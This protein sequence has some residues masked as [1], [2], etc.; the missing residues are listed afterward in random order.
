ME[1]V[2]IMLASIG[3]E[4]EGNRLGLG[5]NLFSEEKTNFE[6]YGTEY[7]NGELKK[8]SNFYNYY[9]LGNETEL[10]Q[11]NKRNN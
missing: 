10:V 5:V 8:N 6:K 11:E 2:A 4:I 9:I 1:N 3:V 7:V